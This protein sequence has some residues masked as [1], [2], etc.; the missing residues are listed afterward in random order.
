MANEMARQALLDAALSV[1]LAK[2]HAK[3]PM[4]TEK[5]KRA[6]VTEKQQL[7]LLEKKQ[8]MAWVLSK[9]EQLLFDQQHK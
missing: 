5:Q 7:V 8:H 3:D 6:R 9:Q 1:G 4:F 2:A